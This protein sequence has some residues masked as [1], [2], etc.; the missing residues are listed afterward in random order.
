MHIAISLTF[1]PGKANEWY[2]RA[3]KRKTAEEIMELNTM[4]RHYFKF[5]DPLPWIPKSLCLL[6]IAPLSY[7][8]T[9]ESGA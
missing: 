7:Y 3:I 2:R 8:N 4:M 6:E 1:F 9:K 5:S